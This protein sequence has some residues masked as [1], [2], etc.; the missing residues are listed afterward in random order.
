MYI[1]CARSP[2]ELES[3]IALAAVTFRSN[4]DVVTALDVKLYLM[5]PRVRI[6]ENDVVVI[7]DD[8]QKILGTC[9]LIDRLFNK[10]GI[11]L[12]GTFLSSICIA[13]SMRGKGLSS[14]LMNCAIAEC[15]SRSSDFAI[16][17]ARRAVDHFY[18][19]FGF[20]GIS[21]YSKL[22]FKFDEIAKLNYRCVI[23]SATEKD[24]DSIEKIHILVYS[25]LLGSCERSLE[26]W[27]HILWKTK[28]Q[29][30]SFT[31]FQTE[32][33]VVGYVIHSASDIFE[34]AAANGASYL[35]LLS[36]LGR[37]FSVKTFAVHTSQYHPIVNEL[38]DLDF[39]I[40]SRQCS[41]GGHMVRIVADKKMLEIFRQ[42]L[43]GYFLG[44]EQTKHT[45]C[46]KHFDVELSDADISININTSAFG[47]ENTCHLMGSS[48]LSAEPQIQSLL[49]L[50]PFNVPVFDQ[51]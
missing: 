48:Y 4:E 21:T 51:V 35:D 13:E 8:D 29:G 22:S 28:W 23:R 34:I 10:K 32:G 24:I 50:R 16:L 5:S 17:I 26:N 27:R 38:R 12:K 40:Y 3:A 47:Y 14:Q 43:K 30:A 15:E 6:T 9:F 19:K 20:W 7:A 46:T 45:L 1:G 11:R 33:V 44:T 49:N 37:E 18:N 39:S 41:Y 2:Q 36:C 25:F 31:I 42:D